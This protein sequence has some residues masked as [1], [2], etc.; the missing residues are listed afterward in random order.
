MHRT[1]KVW[2]KYKQL[3]QWRA[4][5]EAQCNYNTAL[6]AKKVDPINN[7]IVENERDTKKLHK[8]FSNMT[9]NISENPLPDSESDEELANNFADFFIHK[10]QKIRDSLEHHPK[11]D[12]RKSTTRPKEVLRQLSKVSE[13]EVKKIINGTTTKSCKS[14]LIP[15]SL[16]NR[17]YQQ[18]SQPLSSLFWK[19]W[20]SSWYSVISGL[21]QTCPSWQR[22]LKNVH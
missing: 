12:L 1:E 17:F 3:H 10:M 22:P 6:W 13:D 5:R 19:N 9:G 18:L 4:F 11:Y 7:I 16:W 15:N 20:D 21:C 2:R 8:I 14:D